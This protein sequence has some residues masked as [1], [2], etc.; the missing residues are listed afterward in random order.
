MSNAVNPIIAGLLERRSCRAFKP[1]QIAEESIRA[2]IEAGRFAATAMALQPQ[3][4]TVVQNQA[5][6]GRIA[7]IVKRGYAA[8]DDERSRQHAA[9]PDYHTFY[10][11]PTV[12]FVSADPAAKYGEA[13]CA[14]AV[15]NMAVAAHSLGLG[16][17]YIAAMRLA[18]AGA[19]GPA[20]K[21]EL[22]LPDN[23][24]VHFA[25]ALGQAAAAPAQPA[26]RRQTVDWVN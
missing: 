22:G 16:S 18:F 5:L 12:I 11:A 23:Y 9:N 26:P 7:A 1:E 4:F 13:D 2:V 10:K 21:K 20:L 8:M 3:C 14:N 15:Q 19:D 17:C 24:A 6:L 25:L